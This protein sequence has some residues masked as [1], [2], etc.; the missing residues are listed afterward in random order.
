M[1][2]VF[3]PGRILQN[4]VFIGDL[5]SGQL[6]NLFVTVLETIVQF[7]FR[8]V[9]K[10][11]LIQKMSRFYDICFCLTRKFHFIIYAAECITRLEVLS[12]FLTVAVDLDT[13]LDTF[14]T[15]ISVVRRFSVSGTIK[16]LITVSGQSTDIIYLR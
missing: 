10:P 2:I 16:Y 9:F 4:D 6:I 13:F 8:I 12:V 7:V 5:F 1:F 15:C 3:S 11:W 14:K